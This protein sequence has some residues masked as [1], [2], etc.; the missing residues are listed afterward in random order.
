M[1]AWLKKVALAVA[2]TAGNARRDIP[3]LGKMLTSTVKRVN[4]PGCGHNRLAFTV[5]DLTAPALR[6]QLVGLTK[7]I[8]AQRQ[9]AEAKRATLLLSKRFQ[10]HMV[11]YSGL[12]LFAFGIY[13]LITGT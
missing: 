3:L 2:E 9:E 6:Q 8:L 1:F 7:A 5:S 10:A 12:A 11:A 4:F 13:C